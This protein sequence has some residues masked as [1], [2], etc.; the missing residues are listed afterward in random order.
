[1]A[2]RQQ[3]V[4]WQSARPILLDYRPR[5]TWFDL[6]ARVFVLLVRSRPLYIP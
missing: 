2:G 6:G 1:M 5:Y 4:A 3:V